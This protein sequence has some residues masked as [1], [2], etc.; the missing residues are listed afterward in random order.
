MLGSKSELLT[1][2]GPRIARPQRG[3]REGAMKRRR[4]LPHNRTSS[5]FDTHCVRLLCFL[6]ALV[7]AS[8]AGAGALLA[9]SFAA[10]DLPRSLAVADLDGDTI[11]DL[12]TTNHDSN[13]VSVKLGTFSRNWCVA[14]L[15]DTC[16]LARV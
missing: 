10:G 8:E 15:F 4:L 2:R 5:A 9:R 11:A 12:V 6:A 7:V 13:D 14:S 16:Q 3:G 1:F